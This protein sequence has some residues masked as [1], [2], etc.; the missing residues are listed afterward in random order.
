M[1]VVFAVL[2]LP[3]TIAARG[4]NVLPGDV[5]IARA[6]QAR[7]SP[8]LD[9]LALLLTAIGRAWPGEVLIA[10]TIVVALLIIGARRSAVLVAAAAD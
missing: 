10:V 4:P 5:E 8:V 1:A 6:V 2:A 3:L 7:S 9:N